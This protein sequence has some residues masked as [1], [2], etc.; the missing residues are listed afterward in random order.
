MKTFIRVFIVS[1]LFF[2]VAFY[3]GA[4]TSLKEN[5]I[6]I[7]NSILFGFYDGSEIT[8]KLITKLEVKPK[9]DKTFITLE[10]AFAN[11]SRVNFLVTGME[12]VRTD[13]I[14]LVSFNK[15][16][17]KIDVI[18]IPRDTYVH[19]KNYNRGE[20]RKI[21]SVYFSHG[22]EGLKKTVSHIME[23]IPLH[24][25]IMIDYEGVEEI[26]NLIGG[27]EVDV[28]FDLKY[29]DPYADPPLNINL[30]K[31]IQTLNGKKALEFLRWRKDNRNKGYI[32]GDLG[33]IKAQQQFLSS[34]ANKASENLLNVVI[35]GFKYVDSD[36]NLMEV[37]SYARLALG[38]T[39][40]DIN[41]LILPGKSDLR[42]INR[43]LF[44]YYIYNPKETRKLLEEIY[45]VKP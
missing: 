30:K 3:I 13:T 44:S 35:K 45:N 7:E 40:E 33:R 42:T 24:H 25:H 17:K 23:G 31:G 38:M 10:D 39:S 22:T 14:L 19:R 26:V 20:E 2:S 21:N 32:D 1:V 41:F 4:F 27:V 16:T 6:S 34:F 5:N 9:E 15:D 29:K 28:P 11:S 43:K 37:I 12:D 18:S 36:I 8:K